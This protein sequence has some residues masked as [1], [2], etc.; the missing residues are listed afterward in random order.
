MREQ[1]WLAK[2]FEENR[3]HLR[4]V[5]YRMLF[6]HSPSKTLGSSKSTYFEIRSVFA[7]STRPSQL[8]PNPDPTTMAA[9]GH[10]LDGRRP[11]IESLGHCTEHLKGARSNQRK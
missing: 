11:L 3:R 10:S 4:A 2:T 6:W 9:S 1:D 8:S 7:D 5:A